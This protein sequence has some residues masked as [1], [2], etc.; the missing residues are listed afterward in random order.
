MLRLE[1]I[2]DCEPTIELKRLDTDDTSTATDVGTPLL[3]LCPSSYYT[4]GELIGQGVGGLVLEPNNRICSEFGTKV[5]GCRHV[6]F[7]QGIW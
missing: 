5:S 2:S 6:W 4:A 1:T 3:R 7:L